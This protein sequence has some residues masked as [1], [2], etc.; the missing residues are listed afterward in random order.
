[1]EPV[2]V[3]FAMTRD[4]FVGGALARLKMQTYGPYRLA[5][6]L[7]GVGMLVLGIVLFA[8]YFSARWP[9]Q[10]FGAVCVVF[11]AFLL[12][13]NLPAQEFFIRRAAAA[14]FE[15]GLAGIAACTV[16]FG[17][18][19]VSIRSERYDADLPYGMLSAA[20]ADGTAI[21][22]CTAEDESRIVP[23]RAMTAD[24]QKQVESLL[25][26]KMKR[27]FKQEGT[28]EWTK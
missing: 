21:L 12:F 9:M 5:N 7:T 26:A 19:G 28:R 3:S 25:A 16:S 22:L 11:G 4:D 1:M 6:R 10:W 2:T 18:N 8:L 23:V 20:Y 17:E 13:L 15:Q 14:K 24:E 27:K